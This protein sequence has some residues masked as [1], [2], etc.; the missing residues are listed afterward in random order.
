MVCEGYSGKVVRQVEVVVRKEG[1]NPAI[2][3]WNE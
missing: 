3:Y 1:G 2:L